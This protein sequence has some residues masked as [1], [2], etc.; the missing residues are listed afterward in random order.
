H[1]AGGI[2]ASVRAARQHAPGKPVEV[3]VETLAELEQALAAGCDRV[4]LD[5]FSLAQMVDAVAL[6]AGRVELEA[7]G[8]VTEQTL[9][10]IAETGVDYISIGA[11]TKDCKALDLSMR[12][13]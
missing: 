13:L 5:N 6:S 10:P 7:S 8:N 3:E 2:A 1:A 4:M 12:L 11:L 9:R